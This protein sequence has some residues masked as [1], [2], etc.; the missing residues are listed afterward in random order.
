MSLVAGGAASEPRPDVE[1]AMRSSGGRSGSWGC[2]QDQI[3]LA[4]HVL[5]MWRRLEEKR[6]PSRGP[7]PCRE[8][9]R[10]IKQVVIV[11]VD[12][13]RR[14][15]LGWKSRGSDYHVGLEGNDTP[16]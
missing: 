1:E 14:R 9:D 8:P 2:E 15:Q 5:V 6:Q 4:I 11:V 16:R 7:G 12:V 3:D 13:Q 10:W